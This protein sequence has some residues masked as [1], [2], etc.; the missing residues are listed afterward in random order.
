MTLNDI[1]FRYKNEEFSFFKYN[2]SDGEPINTVFVLESQADYLDKY[3]NFYKEL[4]NL[5]EVIV[6]AA[7]GTFKITNRGMAYFIRHGHQD[8][9]TDK[10]GNTRGVS[11]EIT[12]LVRNN[13]LTRFNDLE[14]ATTFDQIMKIVTECKVRGFGEL[15][16]Y[17]TSLRIA[18]YKNIEPDKVFLCAGTRAGSEI[19]EM[20]G[21]VK[22]GT[23]KKRFVSD[24]ELPL[25][26][27]TQS[28]LSKKEIHNIACLYKLLFRQLLA[29]ISQSN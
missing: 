13:L 4:P 3:L 2:D 27:R 1:L 12:K 5:T 9:F 11:K 21:F 28:G 23:S 20:K 18:A 19:L 24:E 17:D 29:R 14:N 6:F 10:E 26:F 25:E 7:D 8:V 22:E 15:S 16:I